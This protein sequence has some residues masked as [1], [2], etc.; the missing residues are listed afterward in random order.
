MNPIKYF[1]HRLTGLP[2]PVPALPWHPSC[3]AVSTLATLHPSLVE[4]SV[5][6][7]PGRKRTRP[8][9]FPQPLSFSGVLPPNHIES[10]RGC[11]TEMSTFISPFHRGETEAGRCRAAHC[12]ATRPLLPELLATGTVSGLFFL[13]SSPKLYLENIYGLQWW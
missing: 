8:P 10:R 2:P 3:S 5:R 7:R 6:T 9:L 12:R 1:L 11:G 13:L 4:F